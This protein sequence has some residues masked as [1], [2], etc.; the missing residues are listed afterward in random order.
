M[1]MVLFAF[2]GSLGLLEF[3][4]GLAL[5]FITTIGIFFW[6]S[7]LGWREPKKDRRNGL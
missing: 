5:L 3:V 1:P 2:V 7:G 4:G 6:G